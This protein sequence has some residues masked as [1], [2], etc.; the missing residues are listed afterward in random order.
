[1][2]TYEYPRPGLTVDVVVL[3]GT[4]EATSVL[5]VRRGQEPFRGRWALPGGFVDEYERLEDAARRELSEETG[6]VAEGPLRQVG[7]F[8][9]PGRDPRGWTVSVAFLLELPGDAPS[10]TGADDADEA[11]W[12]R[13]DALPP[14]AFDHDRIV[15][16]AL[17][18]RG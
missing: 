7:T 5:L 13:L 1:M 10:V 8:G 4:A 18:A 6:L 11:A 12:H 9:D 17:A 3:A 2:H 16:A 14:L 15:A